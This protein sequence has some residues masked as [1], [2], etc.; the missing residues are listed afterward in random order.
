MPTT[1][2]VLFVLF[3]AIG[4]AAATV[5]ASDLYAAKVPEP[6]QGVWHVAARPRPAAWKLNTQTGDLYYCTR[7]GSCVL[8]KDQ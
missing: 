3:L 7:A 4:A 5:F 8:I 2:S 6:A 1:T